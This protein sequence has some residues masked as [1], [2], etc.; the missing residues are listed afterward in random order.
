MALALDWSLFNDTALYTWRR[1]HLF[2]NDTVFIK[3]MDCRCKTVGRESNFFGNFSKSSRALPQ[4][5]A[6]VDKSFTLFLVVRS[7]SGDPS[8]CSAN[9]SLC[10]FFILL[11]TR[12][13]SVCLSCILLFFS[14][15]LFSALKRYAWHCTLRSNAL[16][17]TLLVLFCNPRLHFLFTLVFLITTGELEIEPLKL[18]SIRTENINTIYWT[19]TLT[20]PSAETYGGHVAGFLDEYQH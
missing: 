15:I 9:L 8:V 20:S 16:L 12:H 3:T 17:R 18:P 13:I 10:P 11:K 4:P 5:T 14:F 2:L 7:V 1:V 19:F 6:N